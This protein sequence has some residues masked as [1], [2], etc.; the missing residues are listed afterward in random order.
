MSSTEVSSELCLKLKEKLKKSRFWSDLS[1]E[2]GSYLQNL[3]AFE[4]RG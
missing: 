1:R 2:S 4:K 3:G